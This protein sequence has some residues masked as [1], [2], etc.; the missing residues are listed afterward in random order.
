MVIASS[1]WLLTTPQKRL[2]PSMCGISWWKDAEL[3]HQSQQEIKRA[4]TGKLCQPSGAW[5]ESR[6]GCKSRQAQRL[7]SAWPLAE[8]WSLKPPHPGFAGNEQ[9][10][11]CAPGSS[12]LNLSGQ[13]EKGNHI[14]VGVGLSKERGFQT[15]VFFLAFQETSQVPFH[16]GCWRHSRQMRFPP[17]SAVRMGCHSG[18]RVAEHTV[19]PLGHRYRCCFTEG[20]F[21][22]SEKHVDIHN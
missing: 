15:Q 13:L 5:E 20:I 17:G 8:R 10:E 4:N 14:A 1:E 3:G 12:F 7:A 21:L 22:A 9:S 16:G 6:A 19:P 2:P 11:P 18:L